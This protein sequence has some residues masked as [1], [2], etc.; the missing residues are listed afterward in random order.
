VLAALNLAYQ[1]ADHENAERAPARTAAS[2]GATPAAMART[3]ADA[4]V[5]APVAEKLAEMVR[6][7]DT[8]L[9]DDGH[10]L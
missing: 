6:R 1:L 5:S 2:K 3:T 7:I 10:L 4:E 8:A 9:G